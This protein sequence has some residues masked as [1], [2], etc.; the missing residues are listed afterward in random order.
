MSEKCVEPGEIQEGDLSAYVDGLADRAVVEHIRRCAACAQ[1]VREIAEAQVVLTAALFR[2]SCPASDQLIAFHQ[3]ELRGGE[4]L[5]VAQHLRECPHC[6]RELATIVR[7]ER[8]GPDRWLRS[9]VE[10]LEAALMPS[11]VPAAALRGDD[12]EAFLFPRVYQAGEVE[13]ILDV[14]PASTHSHRKD[15]SG[16]VHVGGQVPETIGG[17][18]AEL[19]RGEGL[20]AVGQVGPRG[21]FTFEA[22][23]PAIYELALLWGDREIRLRGIEVG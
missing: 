7:E 11:P 9:A 4:K 21:R 22:L 17:T 5:V 1:Q 20:I 12:Q 2:H 19:F 15:L 13:V 8:T 3:G 10:V 6:A 16:L 14:R 23:A 18:P